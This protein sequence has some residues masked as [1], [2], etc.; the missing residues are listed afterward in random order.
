MRI[1]ICFAAA[2]VASIVPASAKPLKVDIMAG[3]SNRV[4]MDTLSGA[5]NSYAG[6]CLSS[7][8]EIPAAPLDIWQVGTFKT[9]PLAV[10]KAD[11][12]PARDPISQGSFEVPEHGIYQIQ[13]G[14]AGSS[15]A[16]MEVAGKPAY[17]Q[18]AVSATVT[19]RLPPGMKASTITPVNLRG[20]SVGKSEPVG[21]DGFEVELKAFAP[22]SFLLE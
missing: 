11:G 5:R 10:F 21:F 4:G 14:S 19:I 18:G 15:F 8:P 17:R 3:Q 2:L 9:T 13:C 7:D 1:P 12:T 16:S 20:E 6:I 22:A